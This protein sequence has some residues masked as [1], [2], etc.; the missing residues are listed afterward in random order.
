MTILTIDKLQFRSIYRDYWPIFARETGELGAPLSQNNLGQRE[1][2]GLVKRAG[3]GRIKFHG[4][5]HTSATLALKKG[6][7][8]KV[9]QE[10]LGHKNIAITLDIFAHVLPSMQQDAA[11][12][13][14]AVLHGTT[15]R[16]FKDYFAEEFCRRD[17]RC[18]CA[19]VQRS[20]QIAL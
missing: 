13:L 20:C 14:A 19:R 17:W 3:V 11:E 8:A 6:V 15:E 12:K 1:Y 18:A 4:L 2:E 7:S 10:R 16:R 5:R 9:V